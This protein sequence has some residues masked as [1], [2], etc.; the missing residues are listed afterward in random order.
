META[1]FICLSVAVY[2]PPSKTFPGFSLSKPDRVDDTCGT[3][4]LSLCRYSYH[5]DVKKTFDCDE[6]SLSVDLNCGVVTG[7]ETVARV[8]GR[9]SILPAVQLWL[10]VNR[11]SGDREV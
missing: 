10:E 4:F 8:V 2:N 11:D 5:M 3:L 9:V 7:R 6:G 1:V